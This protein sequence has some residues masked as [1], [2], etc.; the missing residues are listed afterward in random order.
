M[1]SSRQPLE[2]DW[3]RARDAEIR[4]APWVVCGI[5]NMQ[6]QTRVRFP[7]P[8][9]ILQGAA[10]VGFAIAVAWLFVEV[11]AGARTFGLFWILPLAALAGWAVADF[12]SGAVHFLADNFGSP[13]TPLIGPA[14]VKPFR[15]HHTDPTGILANSFLVA[16]GGNCVVVLPPMVLVLAFVPVASTPGGYVFGAFF[17]VFSLAIF[18]TNQFHKW[19]HMESPPRAVAWLQAHGVILS[20]E[21]HDIHHRSPFDTHYCITAG[22]WNP[23]LER[24]GAFAWIIRKV[25]G[26]YS[27]ASSATAGPGPMGG[28]ARSQH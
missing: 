24:T 9:R 6:R 4:H 27:D 3:R 8:L 15:D 13:E 26:D 22:W 25:R 16:N 28:T 7:D 12:V 14:F 11:A 19:A 1:S 2:T 17:L 23:L 10:Y 21:H 18:L 20:R 5:M